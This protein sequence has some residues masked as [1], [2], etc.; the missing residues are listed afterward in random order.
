MTALIPMKAVIS[1]F[2]HLFCLPYWFCNYMLGQAKPDIVLKVLDSLSYLKI[3]IMW[4]FNLVWFILLLYSAEKSW[5]PGNK[6]STKT[7]K[8]TMHYRESVKKKSTKIIVNLNE[9]RTRTSNFLSFWCVLK[10]QRNEVRAVVGVTIP[11]LGIFCWE[12]AFHVGK[13]TQEKNDFAPSEKYSSYAPGYEKV[14]RYAKIICNVIRQNE[15]E[16]ANTDF[17]M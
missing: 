1:S 2:H 8:P 17:E 15:S 10:R 5:P 14:F 11:K 7:T 4:S 9:R 6:W 12:K 16:L 3:W 13:K